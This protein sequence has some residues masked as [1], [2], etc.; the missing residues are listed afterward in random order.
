M[1]YEKPTE[2]QLYTKNQIRLFINF[3]SALHGYDFKNPLYKEYFSK[4]ESFEDKDNTK[5]EVN[6]NFNE[7]VF[8]EIERKNV[9]YLLKLEKMIPK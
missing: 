7:S 9:N 2:I 1:L 6:P 4:L 8:N 5:Y 3:F